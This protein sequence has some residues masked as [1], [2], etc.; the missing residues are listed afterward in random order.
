M[1][2]LRCLRHGPLLFFA[3]LVAALTAVVALGVTGTHRPDPVPV[4]QHRVAAT[5][6]D[7]AFMARNS[8]SHLAALITA[9]QDPSAE[10]AAL[11]AQARTYEDSS[12]RQWAA[13][14][15]DLA[16]AA[17]KVATAGAGGNAGARD[18]LTQLGAAGDRLA[19]LAAGT[20]TGADGPLPP[21]RSANR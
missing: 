9:G 8:I 5:Q 16:V 6:A 19:T 15:A 10:A 21:A 11:E 14:W 20:L 13:A 12:D 2:A 17:D 1:T 4:D 3:A 18:A 7:R